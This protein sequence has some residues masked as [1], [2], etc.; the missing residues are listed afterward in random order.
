MRLTSAIV[1]VAALTA[2]TC[3]AAEADLDGLR[4][5]KKLSAQILESAFAC[6]KQTI[7]DATGAVHETL[8]LFEIED[9]L[10][11][12]QQRVGSEN[13]DSAAILGFT[14]R[15][16]YSRFRIDAR[17][18]A[19]ATSTSSNGEHQIRLSCKNN[20]LC[21]DDGDKTKLIDRSFSFVMCDRNTADNAVRA[22][23]MLIEVF[24]QKAKA[25]P[26]D[27]TIWDHN[28]SRVALVADDSKRSFRFIV[29]RKG[30]LDAGVLRGDLLFE[31]SLSEEG[32]VYGD[33]FVFSRK[34][35]PAKYAVKG[36]YN[37]SG[38]L[39]LQGYAPRRNDDCKT[40]GTRPD[41][42]K[43]RFA[44]ETNPPAE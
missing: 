39:E 23:N 33:A 41:V 25:I 14:S 5:Q 21:A 4:E 2:S 15:S 12:D 6:P 13:S 31:G 38:T 32:D 43:F 42:L 44:Q 19:K 16:G 10:V 18:L 8:S 35:G 20:Q 24:A 37:D 30:L 27:H 29:P 28:G 40:V 36:R 11:I 3:D 34:C 1:F 17:A 26:E 7:R 22:A 9:T